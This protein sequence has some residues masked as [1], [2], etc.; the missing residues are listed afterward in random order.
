[1]NKYILYI[2]L[3]IWIMIYNNTYA[4]IKEIWVI[5]NGKERKVFSLKSNNIE[6]VNKKVSN[7]L[8]T[9]CYDSNN[10]ISE[11]IYFVCKNEWYWK[12]L[13]GCWFVR[14]VEDKFI[15]TCNLKRKDINKWIVFNIVWKDY[16]KYPIDFDISNRLDYKR[17]Q[18]KELS[19]ESSATAD[20]ISYIKKENISED[21]VLWKLPKSSFWKAA[22]W[23]NWKRIWWNP[24]KW[25]VWILDKIEENGRGALQ[26]K[27]EG[28]G[29]YEKPISKVY[30]DYWINNKIINKYNWNTNWIKNEKE[31][32]SII[33]KSLTKWY[34]IQLWGDTCTYQEYEDGVLDKWKITQEEA[35]KW[36]NGKN[37][38]IYPL[39]ERKLTW[40][41]KNND[42]TLTKHEWLNWEHAFYLLWYTGWI[43]NPKTIIVWDTNT[44]RHEYKTKE[45]LRKWE[46]MSYRS[47]I[48][49]N[50]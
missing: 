6:S 38:C 24:E 36:Y 15:G 16:N 5:M 3:I 33:L 4:S 23:D 49:D 11:D 37:K 17:I 12:K 34:M 43:D 20:I 28:Y 30:N 13:A 27:Y 46:R 35:D 50:K 2:F 22:Y 42:W 44:G 26:W 45:W 39:S 8:D 31:H 19:C 1:M 14:K 48:V 47:I 40:Y 21:D 7:L 29:V 41:S 18:K 10:K 9:T 32:L 25:F